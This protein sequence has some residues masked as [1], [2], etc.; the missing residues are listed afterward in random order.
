MLSAKSVE[1]QPKVMGIPI[2]AIA[3]A[4]AFCGILLCLVRF[5]Y[6]VLE[7][8]LPGV[9]AEVTKEEVKKIILPGDSKK[10]LDDVPDFHDFYE[11]P[12]W[13]IIEPLIAL[14]IYGV[15]FV[16]MFY[17]DR[18][19]FWVA[20]FGEIIEFLYFAIM[21]LYILSCYI[22]NSKIPAAFAE[23][24]ATKAAVKA[25][26]LKLWI[27]CLLFAFVSALFAVLLFVTYRYMCER[28]G[29]KKAMQMTPT[30][31]RSEAPIKLMPT[32]KV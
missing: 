29:E 19:L 2:E 7:P 8:N 26:R 6:I 21:G 30:S 15:I 17:S 13:Y 1:D 23:H 20:I 25:F 27:Y 16:A 14:V 22:L 12:I 31:A 18:H 3:V 9:M 10:I 5:F 4:I 32:E 11:V 24:A 28:E